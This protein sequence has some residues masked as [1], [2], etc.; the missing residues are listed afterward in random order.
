MNQ[1]GV[2]GVAASFASDRS[3]DGKTWASLAPA[4]VRERVRERYGAG[5]ILERSGD[6]ASRILADWG[7]TAA[8]VGANLVYAAM[9]HFGDPTRVISARPFRGLSAD[10]CG[11]IVDAIIDYLPR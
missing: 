4:T 5:P 9:H 11:V 2:D 8:V 7:D 1:S 10:A 3:P 6:L